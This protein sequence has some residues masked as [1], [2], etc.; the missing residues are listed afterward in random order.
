V[1]E[2]RHEPRSLDE[3]VAANRAYFDSHVIP[4][5]ENA[6]VYRVR[7][8]RLFTEH[9]LR[10]LAAGNPLSLLEVGSGA[11]LLLEAALAYGLRC[12]ALD[13]SSPM[14]SMTRAEIVERCPTFLGN[15]NFVEG[16]IRDEAVLEG[17]MFQAIVLQAVIHLF[18][19]VVASRIVAK[20]TDHIQDGGYLWILRIPDDCCHPFRNDCCHLF[21][22]DCCHAFRGIVATPS[23]SG[24]IERSDA[25]YSLVMC[26]SSNMRRNAHARLENI[27]AENTRSTT[28]QI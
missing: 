11:G 18:P 12:T 3:I 4:Y 7:M 9:F 21:R 25:G 26:Q 19:K 6:A 8:H 15:V 23:F 1:A 2:Q 28:T 10:H 27:H 22:S 16:D 14:L 5:R 24:M 17:Q 20:L 13:F